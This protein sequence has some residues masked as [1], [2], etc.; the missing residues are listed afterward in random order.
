M[1]D[2]PSK[3]EE[4]DAAR[5]LSFVSAMHDGLVL[6]DVMRDTISY[7]L[8]QRD[9]ALHAKYRLRAWQYLTDASRRST[10]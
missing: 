6:H 7:A 10:K 8:A 4:F 1:L 3:R 9:P 5:N 2:S